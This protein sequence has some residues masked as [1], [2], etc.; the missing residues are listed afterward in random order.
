[1]SLMALLNPGDEGGVLEPLYDPTCRGCACWGRFARLVRLQPPKW[2]LPRAELAAASAEDRRSCSTPDEP[3]REVSLGESPSSPTCWF[4]TTLYAIL[5]RGLRST[6][7]LTVGDNSADDPA[8]RARTL[9]AHRSAGK[10]FSMTGWRSATSRPADAGAQA[11]AGTPEHHLC[12][13]P[14]CSA[15]WRSGWPGRFLLSRASRRDWRPARPSDRRSAAY[16]LCGCCRCRGVT[17]SPPIFSRWAAR[18]RR[19]ICRYITEHA[20]VT[21]IPD[22][23]G[24]R[25]PEP[26]CSLAFC[27]RPRCW[28]QRSSGWQCTSPLP[29]WRRLRA[30]RVRRRPRLLRPSPSANHGAPSRDARTSTLRRR[31][32]AMQSE[33]H[34]T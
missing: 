8:R 21:A 17:S 18:R 20:R 31:L 5:R 16:R 1:V 13:S 32:G 26:L 34:V 2:E 28:T 10:T 24:G 4:A 14:N 33:M 27:K 29:A 23:R 6:S 3:D 19:G 22:G 30:G 11:R 7:P 9:P 15:R 25:P 12:H